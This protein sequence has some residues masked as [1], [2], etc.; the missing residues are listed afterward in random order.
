[1]CKKLLSLSVVTAH[2]K[3]F[4]TLTRYKTRPTI[5]CFADTVG[6]VIKNY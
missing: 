3:R 2:T 6:K 1:M 5:G 4:T